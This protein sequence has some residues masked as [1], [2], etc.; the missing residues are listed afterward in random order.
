MAR[1]K[2]RLSPKCIKRYYPH[3][4]EIIIR[5]GGLG[6]RLD[7][8]HDL[9]AERG[10]PSRAFTHRKK[11]EFYIRWCFADLA[12]AVAFAVEFDG[13]IPTKRESHLDGQ[14]VLESAND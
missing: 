2:G 14:S 5:P 11:G 9:C 12:V 7:A 10:I 4:V 6:R 8:M 1:Y 3:H 13:S